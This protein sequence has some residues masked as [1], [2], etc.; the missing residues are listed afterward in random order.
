MICPFCG[1]PMTEPHIRLSDL[2][3]LF[4]TCHTLDELYSVADPKGNDDSEPVSR[5]WI[6]KILDD[7]A[8]GS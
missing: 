6:N 7:V 1:L 2:D 3:N 8:M 4:N 5:Q